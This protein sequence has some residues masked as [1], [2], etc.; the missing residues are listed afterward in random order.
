[1]LGHYDIFQ[2]AVR[3][4]IL[5]C[6]LS[7]LKEVIVMYFHNSPSKKNDKKTDYNK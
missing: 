4:I 1:M 2:T 5:A 7:I 3:L 6:L